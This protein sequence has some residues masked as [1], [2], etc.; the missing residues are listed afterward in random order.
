MP[1]NFDLLKKLCETP[2]VSSREYKVRALVI[3]ELKP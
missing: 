1:I 3:E 2:G